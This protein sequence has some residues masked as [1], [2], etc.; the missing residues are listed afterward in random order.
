MT[1]PSPFI[2]F[3]LFSPMM[4][5]I[6]CKFSR[7]LGEY[8]VQGM[9]KVRITLKNVCQRMAVL[10]LRTVNKCSH[11]NFTNTVDHVS[12]YGSSELKFD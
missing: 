5:A 8:P 4:M 12:W 3:I 9:Q 1:P 2:K 6:H 7:K 11:E 10:R